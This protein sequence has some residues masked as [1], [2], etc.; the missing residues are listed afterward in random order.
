MNRKVFTPAVVIVSLVL[1]GTL[2]VG[3]SDDS[4][5]EP[6]STIPDATET[7]TVSDSSISITDVWAR[8]SPMMTSAGAVYMTIES[9]GD[10]AL[11]AAAVDP[12]IATGAQ[13]H[14]TAMDGS[15]M[16]MREV[17]RVEVTAG[18]PRVLEPGGYHVMLTGLSV[19]L[20]LGQVFDVVLTF[21]NA[22]EV[23]ATVKVREEAP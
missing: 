22:G 8:T 1:T 12:L 14:E 9:T 7:V 16:A 6:S 2:V 13:V 15:E 11:L 10:D 18:E 19:P 23:T 5:D 21:E 3:C 17:E 20:E 4:T